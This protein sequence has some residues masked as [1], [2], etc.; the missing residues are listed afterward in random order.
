MIL[1]DVFERFAA[2]CPLPVMARATLE[3]ALN[4]QIIDQVFQDIA[5]K[6]YTRKILFSS[7]VDL[8]GL[9]VCRIR[10]AIHAAYQARAETIDAS[11]KAVYDKL[12]RTEPAVAA[13]LVRATADRLA[14]VIAA[15][16]GVRPELLPGYRVKILDGNHLAGT[17]HRIKELRTIRAGALPGQALVVLDPA[18]MLAIDV[19]PCEDGH[20]QERSLLDDVLKTL[21]ARD[22]LIQDRNFC[23][24]KFLF[25]IAR[26]GAFFVVRQHASTLHWEFDGKRRACGRVET[27]KVFEQA[28][29]LTDPETDEVVIVRRVTVVLDQPTRDG[30]AEIHVLTNLPACDA[31]AKAI[32]ELYRARWTIETAFA[33]LE[34]TLEGEV[35]TLGY[36]KAA[37]L[38]FCVA[39]TSYNIL[40][41]VKAALRSAHGDAK[42]A[43]EVSG[44]YVAD[45]VTMTHRGMMIAI[46]EDEWVEFRDL[47]AAELGNVLVKLARAVHLPAYRKHPRGPKKPKPK[48]QS[49]AKI[50]H[51]A[52][53]KILSE[54]Q[55]RTR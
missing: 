40:S 4:P 33:E 39:L 29:R 3:N 50:K 54:R 35:A 44:Y 43:D 18:S 27:G 41:T 17:E 37:L 13:A 34:A 36:P 2:S 11:L 8:M 47:D 31:K 9:V 32:A 5:D 6:Q 24:T 16:G 52:T 51:V 12:D 26:R 53:S 28:V 42:V 20:A 1:G 55:K 48:K 7:V 22:V 14:P 30:D 45:E 15:M 21:R 49:G 23:T 38:A 19:I 46:P 25:G 10:P